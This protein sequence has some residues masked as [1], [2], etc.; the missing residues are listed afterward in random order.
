M[1]GSFS[2]NCQWTL[3][4]LQYLEKVWRPIASL[5]PSNHWDGC[6]SGGSV[7]LSTN[8]K[9]GGS[10][11]G[12]SRPHVEVSSWKILNPENAPKGCVNVCRL[13]PPDEQA[14]TLCSSSCHNY[15]NVACS[16]KAFWVVRRLGSIQIQS[17]YH[18]LNSTLTL[19]NSHYFI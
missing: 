7:G 5:H 14:G 16:V 8:R 3:V 12:S 10:V 18:S 17:I 9:I 15:V 2:K 11:P 1:T 13:L 4:K 6:G 19:G